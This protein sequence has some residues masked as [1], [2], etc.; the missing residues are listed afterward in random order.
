MSYVNYAHRADIYNRTTTTSAAG[1]T[2]ASW[3]AESAGVKCAYIPSVSDMK[4]RVIGTT[5]STDQMVQF[6]FPPDIDI[7]FNKRIYNVKDTYGNIIEDGPIEVTSVVK[8]PFI[9][10]KIHHIEV[11]GHKVIED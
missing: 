5:Y 3:A 10:G 1:Q 4:N 8:S 7:D 11:A 2:V 9:N 6:F